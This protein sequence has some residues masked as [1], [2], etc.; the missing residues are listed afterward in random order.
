M[1]A[2][3]DISASGRAATDL[4][5]GDRI[6]LGTEFLVREATCTVTRFTRSAI[7]GRVQLGIDERFMIT[8]AGDKLFVLAS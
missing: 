7:S 1:S 4:K 5:E 8:V 2:Q 6:V 3:E